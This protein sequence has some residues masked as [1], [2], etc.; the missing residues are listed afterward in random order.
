LIVT[1]LRGSL[2]VHQQGIIITTSDFTK[3]AR[4]EA[5][6]ANKTRIGLINGDE[7][8]D[9]LV[10]HQVGVVKR[11]LEVTV[12]DDEYWSELI[13]Q[14]SAPSVPTVPLPDPVAPRPAPT[15]EATLM[16]GKPKGF[17]LFG[18]FYA[19]NTWRRVLLD[20]CQALA[21]RC[22][23]FATVATTLKGRSRQHIADSPDGM[24]SPAPIPGAALWI[25]TNQSA[26]SVLRIIA[27]LLK[28]LGRPPNDF[29]IVVS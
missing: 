21:Q 6:A 1:Q 9:L 13:G 14:S 26:R 7:L 15:V 27:Q 25:E 8:I 2:Q 11:T 3:D 4:R 28:A 10:K 22:D 20:V 12:L 24:I 18:E 19:A 5:V 23:N 29:E 16:P 17:I